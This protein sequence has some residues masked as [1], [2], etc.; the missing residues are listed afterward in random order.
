MSE[1]SAA[2]VSTASRNASMQAR[3]AAVINEGE[4]SRLAYAR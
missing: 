1:E 3:N 2:F 4:A